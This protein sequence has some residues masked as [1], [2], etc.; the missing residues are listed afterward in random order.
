M[1]VHMKKSSRGTLKIKG[2][3]TTP[4]TQSHTYIN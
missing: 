1:Y 3:R 4:P 2:T